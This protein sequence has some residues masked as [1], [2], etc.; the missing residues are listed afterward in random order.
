MSQNPQ[1]VI[2]NVISNLKIAKRILAGPF[3]IDMSMRIK[4]GQVITEAIELLEQFEVR[5]K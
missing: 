4:V 5:E 2:D 1:S 3:S